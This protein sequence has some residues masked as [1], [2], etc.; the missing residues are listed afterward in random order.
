MGRMKLFTIPASPFGRKVRVVAAEANIADRIEVTHADPWNSTARLSDVNPIGKV[1]VLVVDAATVLYDSSVICE[2]LDAVHGH[3][4]LFPLDQD[5]RWTTLRRHS[6]ADGTL[7]AFIAVRHERR[8]PPT[9]Q[10]PGWIERQLNVVQRCLDAM[11]AEVPALH[12]EVTIAH[13]AFAVTLGHLD[14]RRAN[15]ETHWRDGRNSLADWYARFAE[16]PSMRTT[17]PYE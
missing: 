4:M 16:R 15:V 7:E 6:L 17:V 9:E 3:N 1:P 5:S 14:F 11:E 2:Y 13:V 12:E 10:S 8:R